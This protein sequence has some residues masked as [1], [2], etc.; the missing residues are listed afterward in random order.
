MHPTLN[1]E[2]LV[3]TPI[4]L[5]EVASF[6]EY[7]NDPKNAQY[8]SWTPDYTLESTT[9]FIREIIQTHF[10]TRGQWNQLA[11]FLLP[12][13]VH[14]GDIAFKMDDEG[15]QGEIGFT[16]SRSY[17]GKGLATEAVN[18]FLHYCFSS[19][20][21]HRITAT[22]DSKNLKSIQL[23]ERLKFRREAHYIQNVWFKG[24]WGD[25][26]MYAMLASEFV[27]PS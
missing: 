26:Y 15:K 5:K 24:Q 27:E 13:R 22:T 14:I 1:S 9:E 11:V 19:L 6:M 23:L 8:Q 12:K 20:H 21:L 7:R 18:L 10:P 17:Q 25:E 2:I 4:T 3:I 16:F